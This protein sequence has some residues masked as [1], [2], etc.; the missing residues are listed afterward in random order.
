[1]ELRKESVQMLQIKSRAASQ[2]TFDTDYN[3]PDA[4]P[5]VGRLIQSKGDI[6]MDEVRLSEGKAFI[7]GNLNVD[8]LYVGEENQK[9]SSLG[10]KLS[11]DETLNLEGIA[12]GDKMCLKWEIEDLSVHMIHSRKLNIKAI[13]TFYAVVDEM[14]GIQLP[15]EISEEGISVK[16]K[17]VRLMSLM[18]HK[19][20]TMRI[21]DEVTLVSN[22][23]NIEQLL[24]YTIDVRGMDL[25]PEDNVVRARGELSVFVLYSGEDEENPL[26]W[27]E[28]V[29]PFNTEV[30]CTGCM[31][32]MIPNIGFSVMHQSIEVK[33]DSDGEERVMSVDTVLELDMK[34]YREEEHDLILDVYSPLKECIPRGKEMCLESLLVRNDSK[35]RVSDRIELKE[36]QGKILQICHSQG[37]VKVEKTKIVENGIQ[38]DGIVFMKILYITGNDEMPFY[39]VDGMIPFSHII[40]ANGI[41]EDS[42]FFLQA[43]LEQLSTS[44]IDSNE[45]EV[46]AVISL[47]VLVLQCENRMIIS[48]VEER[49]L[50]MEKI[51]AMPGITVYVVKNGDSMWDIA[52]R[53]Y[54][55]VEEI[56][57]L[58]E[59]EEDRVVPGMPL[60]LVKKVEG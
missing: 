4:K 48:K 6:S 43:D 1:M 57:E 25:R 23:P 18:V 15:V 47:N 31:G 40:E 3:V 5:D 27:A 16:R 46:K 51:Q 54:T 14:A 8:I 58:N 35:C 2:V 59:L 60:L 56:C 12:S 49:P 17:K 33:P 26:Q 52:K 9:V 11:F 42:I 28:Y 55:T 38:A 29:L 21:K 24:W 13:V 45:I 41:N 50:D 39:S 44:M 10:A 20:D 36:S 22:K 7:S 19:K 34:L 30:E 32:E 53:F 37:R